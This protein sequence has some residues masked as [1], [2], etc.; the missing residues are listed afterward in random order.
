[1]MRVTRIS[2]FFFAAVVSMSA[3]ADTDCEKHAKTR[4]DFLACARV[5]TDKNLADSKTLYQFLRTKA[6][7]DKQAVLDKNFS[8]WQ[9]KISSDC[10]VV[11]YSF[12]EWS[13]DYSPDTDFQISACRRKISSQELD[14]YK[15][16]MC[17]DD[18][19]TSTVPK[20]QA[21]SNA[22]AGKN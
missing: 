3:L 7:T 9:D 13:N 10:A 11:G 6:P 2:M 15:Y 8:I 19:E 14:F 5:D 18:M 17:P 21:L 16:V 22:L 20:C 1:M 4:D 12:N